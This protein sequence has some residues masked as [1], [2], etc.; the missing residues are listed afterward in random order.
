MFVPSSLQKTNSYSFLSELAKSESEVLKFPPSLN[1]KNGIITFYSA[2]TIVTFLKEISISCTNEKPE[3]LFRFLIGQDDDFFL[4]SP[5]SFHISFLKRE[6]QVTGYFLQSSY[7]WFPSNWTFE[8]SCDGNKWTLLDKQL[9]SKILCTKNSKITIPLSVKRRIHCSHFK[10]TLFGVNQEGVDL[11][12]LK[13]FDIFGVVLTTSV[14]AS[15]NEEEKKSQSVYQMSPTNYRFYFDNNQI[16]LLRFVPCERFNQFFRLVG[17]DT[18]PNSSIYN[19]I[20]PHSASWISI[21]SNHYNYF[22]ISFLNEWKFCPTGYMIKSADK[23][24]SKVLE[25]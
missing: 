22:S 15:S 12:L 11:F 2:S 24:F 8:G 17:R 13:G 4:C 16:G 9:N 5:C 10:L 18:L 6:V 1:E 25:N 23:C 7:G 3:D 21:D 20:S 14:T 19:I